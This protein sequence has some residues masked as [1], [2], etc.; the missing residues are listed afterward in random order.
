MIPPRASRDPRADP[1]TG[2]GGAAGAGRRRAGAGGAAGAGGVS[3]EAVGGEYVGGFAAAAAAASSSGVGPGAGLGVISDISSP[4]SPGSSENED[5]PG[6]YTRTANQ[7]AKVDLRPNPRSGL[8][9]PALL[10]R[11]AARV[12]RSR[13]M[14]RRRTAWTRTSASPTVMRSPTSGMCPSSISTQPASVSYSSDS[15]RSSP[16][17]SIESSTGSRPSTSHTPSAD[18]VDVAVV[19]VELV[20]DLADDLL[21]DV[22]DRHDARRSRRVRR[23]RRPCGCATRA[24]RRAGRGSAWSPGTNAG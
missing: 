23:R 12:T 16:S 19:A 17:F 14:R 13:A 4:P 11:S 7:R 18:L 1:V 6:P 20:G 9:G 10:A 22:L 2:A 24:S 3:G 15:G 21:D 5:P 8:P